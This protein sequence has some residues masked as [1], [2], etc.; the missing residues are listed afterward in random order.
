MSMMCGEAV[1]NVL[2]GSIPSP[3]VDSGMPAAIAAAFV[4]AGPILRLSRTNAVLTEDAVALRRSI[5][6]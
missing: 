5:W 2:V 6:P 1:P 3:S 4:E